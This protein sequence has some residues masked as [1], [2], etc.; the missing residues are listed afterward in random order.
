MCNKGRDRYETMGIDLKK[1]KEWLGNMKEEEKQK[2]SQCV[3]REVAVS[4][5]LLTC[6]GESSEKLSGAF[7]RGLDS[8]FCSGQTGSTRKICSRLAEPDI[9][10]QIFTAIEISNICFNNCPIKSSSAK[11]MDHILLEVS[12]GVKKRQ[13]DMSTTLNYFQR[14]MCEDLN[15]ILTAETW[16]NTF[17]SG[18]EEANVQTEN[19]IVLVAIVR[20]PIC[21]ILQNRWS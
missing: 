9:Q 15:K 16:E 5:A 10:K 8:F 6:C 17:A 14:S 1:L 21:C 11:R 2:M 7:L 18:W 12:L 19:F 13:F 20:K 4:F 3:T